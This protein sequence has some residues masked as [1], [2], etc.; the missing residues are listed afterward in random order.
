MKRLKD[1]MKA[2]INL[3]PVVRPKKLFEEVVDSIR[4]NLGRIY[5][6]ILFSSFIYYSD[7]ISRVEFD[8]L[9]PQYYQFL[10][11]IQYWKRCNIPR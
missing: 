5:N 11:T 8:Q 4:D 2:A 1:R 6:S 3:D 9:C 7:D 10:P